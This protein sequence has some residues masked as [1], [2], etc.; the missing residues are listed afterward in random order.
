MVILLYFAILLY[1]PCFKT[2]MHLLLPE[3]FHLTIYTFQSIL[4]GSLHWDP[5]T[6]RKKEQWLLLCA[7]QVCL[8]ALLGAFSCFQFNIKRFIKKSFSHPHPLL[9]CDPHLSYPVLLVSNVSFQ[10]FF[11][12]IVANM[13]ICSYFPLSYTKRGY[14]AY[15]L[16]SHSIHTVYPGDI[17]YISIWPLLLILTP[18]P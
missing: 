5:E 15:C 7:W 6:A 10:C 12:Q 4:C 9:P 3:A 13:N 8:S 16:A 1:P 11:M 17:F 18:T 2:E 14:Y